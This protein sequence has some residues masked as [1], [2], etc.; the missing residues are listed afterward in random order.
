MEYITP[1]EQD[2]VV[3][4][5]NIIAYPFSHTRGYI[6]EGV[7]QFLDNIPSYSTI[8]EIGSG[9]GKNLM[10]RKDCYP[11]AFDLSYAFAHITNQIG[12]D[13][14]IGNSIM[15]PLRSN[16][17]DYV[18]NIAVLHHLSSEERRLC[19]VQELIRI[20]KPGGKLMIQVWAKKQPIQS[21]RK[22]NSSEEYVS[23]YNRSKTKKE[24]RY[25]HIYED[26]ELF[27]MLKPL[28]SIDIIE[29]Y[30]E[31]GNWIAVCTKK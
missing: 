4:P 25:Y 12:I 20:L 28:Q 16:S 22:F 6:W 10:R 24:I 29:Y 18:L 21:K 14:V 26:N 19:V 15:I 2:F 7:K 17:A 3:K 5:Y 9:N 23:W 30:W 11:I 27:D 8:V 31:Y 1:I 13:S